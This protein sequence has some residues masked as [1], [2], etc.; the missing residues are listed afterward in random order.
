M[1]S[2]EQRDELAWHF[3]A[4]AHQGDLQGMET[5]VAKDVVL[6]GDGGVK[7]PALARALQGHR[8]VARALLAWARQYLVARGAAVRQAEV[9]D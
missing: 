3:F 6:H 9:N 1:A 5:L 7:G 8:R 2:R 4:P